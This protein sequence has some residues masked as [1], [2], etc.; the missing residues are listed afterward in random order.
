MEDRFDER[1]LILIAKHG[2]RLIASMRLILNDADE[3]GEHEQFI[4]LPESFPQKTDIIE[5]TRV[6]THPEYRGSDL[7]RGLFEYASK[8]A[9]SLDRKWIIG[10]STPGLLPLYEKIG[11]R[12]TGLFYL[13]H[14]LNHQRHHVFLGNKE[15]I[16]LGRNV[17]PIHWNMIYRHVFAYARDQGLIRPTTRRDRWRIMLYEP[18]GWCI[19]LVKHYHRRLRLRRHSYQEDTPRGCWERS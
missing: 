14:D 9:M 18:T 17:G 12:A 8:V 16:L 2:D 5:I 7:L 11:F 15:H 3:T 4:V 13:H 1:S 10:S 19:R 6:C